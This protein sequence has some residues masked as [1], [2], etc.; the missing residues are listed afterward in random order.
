M[1]QDVTTVQHMF[2]NIKPETTPANQDSSS[3]HPTFSQVT[4]NTKLSHFLV[5]PNHP[6]IIKGV[7]TK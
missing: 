2:H 7:S 3:P 4:T 1:A 5:P 6:Y